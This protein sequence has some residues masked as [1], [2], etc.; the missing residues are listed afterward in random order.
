MIVRFRDS[1]LIVET[2]NVSLKNYPLDWIEGLKHL[3]VD[4]ISRQLFGIP[5]E[6]IRDWEFTTQGQ[7][8]SNIRNIQYKKRNYA[9][10][11][12]TNDGDLSGIASEK[13]FFW[14]GIYY[15]DIG[16]AGRLGGGSAK[17]HGTGRQP[18]FLNYRDLS[19]A[20]KADLVAK[21]MTASLVD[22]SIN[23]VFPFT[24]QV[25]PPPVTLDH[26]QRN[27]LKAVF[28]LGG[29][30]GGQPLPSTVVGVGPI[31]NLGSTWY[32]YPD[33]YV[34]EYHAP[35]ES[36]ELTKVLHLANSHQAV[37]GIL[38]QDEP[39]YTEVF[40]RRY[41]FV[42]SLTNKP[43][44]CTYNWGNFY[45]SSSPEYRALRSSRIRPIARVTDIYSNDLYI[46]TPARGSFREFGDPQSNIW[47]LVDRHRA[48]IAEL[49]TELGNFTKPVWMTLQGFGKA[50]VA[51]PD[52]PLVPD[53]EFMFA[54]IWGAV[55]L[56]ASCIAIYLMHTA[57][58]DASN[59]K[60]RSSDR[61]APLIQGISPLGPNKDTWNGMAKAY[62]LIEKY[63]K[64]LLTE[65]IEVSVSSNEFV[66]ILIKEHKKRFFLFCL[67]CFR[68][69]HTAT[70]AFDVLPGSVWRWRNLRT[71]EAYALTT[72]TAELRFSPFELKI[73]EVESAQS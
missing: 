65:T 50:T 42:K 71:S 33:K 14:R 20:Y 62:R 56:G 52:V 30:N 22:S 36:F 47:R 69:N 41:N 67:N 66:I 72:G 10:N 9:F 24:L 49:T 38:Q 19:G 21:D 23:V 58:S 31:S 28:S 15:P 5:Y 25:P 45:A 53:P 64:I 44:F 13:S 54:Q 43:V 12:V 27:G 39:V 73:I 40:D 51:Q 37:I 46:H 8:F 57:A 2:A 55:C 60:R 29:P 16:S 59:F 26:L 70:I 35:G 34:N 3:A 11:H 4:E 7:N 68:E 1:K 61:N 32:N 17:G 48:E 6:E 18:G 63:E